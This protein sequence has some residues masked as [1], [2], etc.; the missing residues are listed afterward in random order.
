M[1]RK[2]D[3]G[4]EGRGVQQERTGGCKKVPEKCS[5]FKKGG[6]NGTNRWDL[7]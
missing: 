5:S 6:K 1:R 4:I 3:R 7:V 2:V